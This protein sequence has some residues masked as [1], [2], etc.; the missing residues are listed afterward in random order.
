MHKQVII[1]LHRIGEEPKAFL[2]EIDT[3]Y[4]GKVRIESE[5]LESLR[6]RAGIKPGER[7][8]IGI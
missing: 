6:E 3:D 2:V 7:Y 1:S 4:S 8:S 5:L